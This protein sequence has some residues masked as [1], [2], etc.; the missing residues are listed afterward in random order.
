[1]LDF[2]IIS[3]IL[4]FYRIF[5]TVGDMRMGREIL[6]LHPQKPLNLDI[7]RPSKEGGTELR[8]CSPMPKI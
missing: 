6:C 7:A 2:K 8:R 3:Y 4:C 5:L 1:M